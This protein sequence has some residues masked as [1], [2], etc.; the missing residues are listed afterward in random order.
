MLQAIQITGQV[1][2]QIKLAVGDQSGMVIDDGNQ[3]RFTVFPVNADLATVHDI[4]LPQI[5][6]QFG[7]ELSAVNRRC[8]RW[9]D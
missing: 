4:T 9:S 8:G 1:F 2:G 6:G 3:V 5:V 7:F